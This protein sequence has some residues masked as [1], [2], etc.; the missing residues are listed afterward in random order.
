LLFHFKAIFQAARLL[1]DFASSSPFFFN[2]VSLFE[3][4]NHNALRRRSTIP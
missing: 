1:H 2:C 4:R 3:F